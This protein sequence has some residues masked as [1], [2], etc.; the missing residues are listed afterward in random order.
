MTETSVLE[1]LRALPPGGE[2][3]LAPSDV[4]L[5]EV[6]LCLHMGR[7]TGALWLGHPPQQVDRVFLRG[8]AVVGL[9]PRRTADTPLLAE[10]LV[11]MKLVSREALAAALEE[12]GDEDGVVFGQ[13]LKESELV[14]A[15]D[16]DR[17]FEE[18]ARRRLFQLYDLPEEPIRVREGIERLAHF[19]PTGVDVRPA[20]AFG[21]VVRSS[22]ERRQAVLA[23]LAGR[24]VRLVAPYDEKRNGY[25]LPPPVL[26]ALRDLAAG[27][28]L[29]PEPK[30]V[31]LSTPE[32]A[33]L[34]LFLEQM[35]LLA[36]DR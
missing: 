16:L 22:T 31:G 21:M 12:G 34:L 18:Q 33:G 10:V 1:A 23:R 26:I 19:H 2:L 27:V 11:A 29:G 28:H 17:A 25:G 24:A 4:P 35:G 15:P 9:L 13:R 14:A 5:D 32:T 36:V 30:L 7:F 8:G 6:L 3:V 20:I